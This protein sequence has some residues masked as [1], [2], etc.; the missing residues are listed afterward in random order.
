MLEN[1][2]PMFDGRVLDILL[3]VREI[4]LSCDMLKVSIASEPQKP[5]SP[6]S[7]SS[8]SMRLP[9]SLGISHGNVFLKIEYW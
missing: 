8:G 6:T 4:I 5:L 9:I 1:I 7:I 2:N 3:Y